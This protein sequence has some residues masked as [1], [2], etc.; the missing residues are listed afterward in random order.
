[1]KA[2]ILYGPPASGKSTVAEALCRR[3]RR[4]VP[5]QRLKAGTGRASEYRMTT[6]AEIDQ[7]DALGQ[8]LWRNH[9]YGSTYAID[10]ATLVALA[11]NAIPVVQLG[12]PEAVAAL[13]NATLDIRW[14]VIAL[15]CPYD[16][17]VQRM[18]D[19]GDV[20]LDAREAAWRETQRIAEP[21]LTVDTAGAVPGDVAAQ[22]DRLV[23]ADP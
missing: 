3:S 22:V 2:V 7:L 4:Y 23:S 19:R 16:V 17:A 8:I 14:Y 13:A 18:R 20:D 11:A 21:D 10:K 9:R 15:Q 5:F 12:Q 6:L 1:M